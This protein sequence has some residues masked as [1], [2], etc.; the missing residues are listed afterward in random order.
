MNAPE[1][2]A[3][4]ADKLGVDPPSKDEFTAILDLTAEAAHSSQRVAG[5]AAAWLAA[6]SGISLD[7]ALRLAK[8]VG[9]E[10]AGGEQTGGAQTGGEHAGGGEEVRGD[11]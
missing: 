9:G 4:F 10:H 7:E 3:E 11:R 8:E 5:P 2:L 6:R 1:W